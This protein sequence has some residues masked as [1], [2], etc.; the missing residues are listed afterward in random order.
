[1]LGGLPI[2]R[3]KRPAASCAGHEAI[4][5]FAVPTKPDSRPRVNCEGEPTRLWRA[6]WDWQRPA[7][8][9]V[10]AELEVESQALLEPEFVEADDSDIPAE[11]DLSALPRWMRAVPEQGPPEEL[12]FE[13]GS[14]PVEDWD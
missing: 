13:A 11:V 9:Q 3:P 7:Q 6:E 1:V 2:P 12:E 4:F 8:V 5:E 10:Q 14:G